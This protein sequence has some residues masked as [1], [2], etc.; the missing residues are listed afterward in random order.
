MDIGS[1]HRA[2]LAKPIERRTNRRAR[3]QRPESEVRRQYTRLIHRRA[4]A[5]NTV[6]MQRS[7]DEGA[8]A[9]VRSMFTAIDG[10]WYILVPKIHAEGRG[11]C[12]PRSV[13]RNV[14]TDG[15]IKDDDGDDADVRSLA[16]NANHRF[17]QAERKAL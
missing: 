3:T 12:A 7:F 8:Q 4:I 11:A 6:S 2:A 5:S 1:R 17:H 13:A 15:R 9:R 16:G 14:T 10:H